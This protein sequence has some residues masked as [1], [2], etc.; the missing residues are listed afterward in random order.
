MRMDDVEENPYRRGLIPTLVLGAIREDL[1]DFAFRI[2]Q[3]I[4]IILIGKILGMNNKI[5]QFN[6]FQTHNKIIIEPRQ[7][8]LTS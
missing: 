8:W 7:L 4:V 5:H 1:N 2:A 6:L 3:V